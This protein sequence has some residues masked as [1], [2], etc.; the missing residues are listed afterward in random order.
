M[1]RDTEKKNDN[2]KEIRQKEQKE[3]FRE[4]RGNKLSTLYTK[5]RK[6]FPV[7]TEGKL[8][9]CHKD[10]KN[11][12]AAGGPRADHGEGYSLS[13]GHISTSNY[14]RRSFFSLVSA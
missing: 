9:P 7:E 1:E 3:F 13:D 8:Q 2:F 10:T 14:S 5:Q 11:S 6:H 12:M 4:V